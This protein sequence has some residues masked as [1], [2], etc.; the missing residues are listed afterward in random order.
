MGEKTDG[1]LRFVRALQVSDG[2]LAAEELVRRLDETVIALVVGPEP[3]GSVAS[4]TT[5]LTAVNLLARLFRRLVIVAPDDALVDKRLPF[6]SGRLG[7][8]LGAFAGR[9]HHDVHAK[10]ADAVPPGATVLHVRD[11]GATAETNEVYCAG[12][13]WLA[14]VARR[15]VSPPAAAGAN[16]VGPL[17]AAA[18]GA[19]EVFKVVFGDVLRGVTPADDVVFSALTYRAGDP[20]VGPILGDVLLPETALV[21]AGSIGSAFLWGLAH[22]REARGTLAVVD[23]DKL[24]AHN[25]DRAILILDEAAALEP[26][27]ASWAFETLRPWLPGLT[28]QPFVG[29][30]RQYVDTL[31]PDY[32]LPLAIAA[33]DSVESRRD[34]QDALPRHILN[35]STGPTK[36]EVSRHNGL[37]DGPCL[38]CLY[39]PEVLERSPLHIAMARTGFEQQRDVAELM[40]PGGKRVLS[41]DN[42]RGIERHNG[43]QPGTLR[44]YVGRQL[45]ELLQDRLWYSQA[46]I[47]TSDGQALVTTA[48]VSALAG[49]LLLAEMLK[50]A[51]PAL[52]SYRLSGVYEQELLGVPNEFL[53]PGKRDATGYCLCHNSMR[54]R[55]YRGKYPLSVGPPSTVDRTER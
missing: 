18:L 49:F 4:Q 9:V 41:D 10:L 35:A 7:P 19:A 27:K 25:P 54:R 12:S 33:V 39:L 5:A 32:R 17:I 42:V 2:G 53:Y 29:T 46:P 22:L 21:G 15:P 44:H 1:R 24:E 36:V 52:A 3:A 37:G 31:S 47:E 6:V 43:L 23:Y 8:A 13:G 51:D 45:P 50:E 26:Q 28:I 20:D 11:S 34:I 16:P 30:I 55:L 38:Y 14:R 48:F 40:I